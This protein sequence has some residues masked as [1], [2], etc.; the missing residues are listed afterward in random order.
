MLDIITSVVFCSHAINSVPQPLN[1]PCDIGSKFLA[2]FPNQTV[3]YNHSIACL[4]II[5]GTF[6][7][8]FD[9][10]YREMAVNK[11]ARCLWCCHL[12]GIQFGGKQWGEQTDHGN[13]QWFDFPQRSLLV[14]L[15]ALGCPTWLF[16]PTSEGWEFLLHPMSPIRH[17]VARRAALVTS[18]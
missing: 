14:S 3:S 11:I 9:K 18:L 1:F 13:T 15:D 5:W 2:Y 16:T 10:F 8:F 12:D 17:S 4:L 7:L 6:F